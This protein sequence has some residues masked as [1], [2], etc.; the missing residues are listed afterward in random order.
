MKNLIS[1]FVFSLVIFSLVLISEKSAFNK[2]N[3]DSDSVEA[4][5]K[6]YIDALKEQ[7]KGKE[8]LPSETVFKDLQMLKEMPAEKILSIMDKGFSNSLGVS[9]EHCHNTEDWAS[10]EKKEKI[11]ARE[12]MKLSGQIRNMI[13]NIK[14]I[15]SENASVSCYTCHR[16]QIIPAT[17]PN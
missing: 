7:I 11:I 1:L 9:C 4:K 10:N 14:E 12:M 8:Q 17:K 16:G 6:I 15:D 13:S 3:S 2:T 5:K